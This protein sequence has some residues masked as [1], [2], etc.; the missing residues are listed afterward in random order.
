M[1]SKL[2]RP[3]PSFRALSLSTARRIEADNLRALSHANPHE[4]WGHAAR[5]IDWIRP[6][7]TVLSSSGGYGQWF[8]DGQLNT[9]FNCLDRHIP[10][11]GDQTALIYDSPVTGTIEKYT[12]SEL[13]DQVCRAVSM[14]RSFGIQRGDRVMIYMPNIPEAA[15]AMLACARMGAVHCVVFGGFAANELATRIKDCTPSLIL[16][17]SCGIDGKK[18]INY[19]VTLLLLLMPLCADCAQVL[20]DEALDIAAATHTVPKS[21]VLLRPQLPVPMLGGRDYSWTECMKKQAIDRSYETM[22]ASD[23]LYIL[24]TSG[25][26][27]SSPPPSPFGA[28]SDRF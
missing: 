13:L 19:K 24:Y 6:P 3:Q 11:R 12:Y 21:I 18:I 8:T 15:I 1:R 2:L 5:D 23:P 26:L 10:S 14:L 4:F 7:K 25:T 22:N 28:L 17:A 27:P 20:L 16:S 9:S